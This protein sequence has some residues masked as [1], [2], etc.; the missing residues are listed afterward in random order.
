LLRPAGRLPLRRYGRYRPHCL[1]CRP[2]LPWWFEI[3]SRVQISGKR[4]FAEVASWVIAVSRN[5]AYSVYSVIQP[6]RICFLSRKVCYSE[7]S[8]QSLLQF[9]LFSL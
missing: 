7:V 1:S 6:C 9:E 5:S 4:S 2:A 3:L 8:K